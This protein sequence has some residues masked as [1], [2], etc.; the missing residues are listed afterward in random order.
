MI[1]IKVVNQHIRKKAPTVACQ[2][3]KSIELQELIMKEE[4]SREFPGTI[5]IVVRAE[6]AVMG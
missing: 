6:V 2:M 5:G 1:D 3:R 4:C